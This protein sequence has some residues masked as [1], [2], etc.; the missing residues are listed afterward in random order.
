MNRLLFTLGDGI[1]AWLHKI[2]FRPSNSDLV[3]NPDGSLKFEGSDWL[4]MF[5]LWVSIISFVLLMVPMVWWSWRY[6]RQPGVPAIRT[7]NHNTAL[8]VTWVV[9]P[10]IVM[11]FIFFWG[12]HGYM[13]TLIAPGNAIEVMITARKWSWAATYPN[14]ATSPESVYLDYRDEGDKQ[15]RGNERVPI[16]VVP[17]G[18]PIK[19]RM[20][21]EDVIHSFYV[22]DMRVKMDVFP[23]RYTSLSFTPVFSTPNPEGSQVG[24]LMEDKDK[25]FS[26]KFLHRDHYLFCAEYCGE[27][28]SE[29]AGIIRVVSKEDYATIVAKWG[30]ID[31][32]TAPAALGE[33]VWKNNCSACHSLDGTAGTGPS[34]KGDLFSSTK[35]HEFESGPPLD[36][37]Q[38]NAWENYI[39]ESIEYPQ[40]KIV[41]GYANGNMPSYKGLSESR[42]NG[43]IAYMR[44]LNGKGRPEDEIV[45]KAEAAA[46]PGMAP[47]PPAPPSPA[48]K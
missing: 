46:A 12:F 9:V 21:S 40:A 4:F 33:I 22:P 34:W 45:P 5:I 32:T 11:T 1:N 7:P 44:K 15:F 8:E 36:V 18:I 38:P 3:V 16:F 41:K 43:V 26:A 42:I 27:N 14:G 24:V 13:K 10:L 35:P 39:R 28:H 31:K 17:A 48:P 19:F 47:A 25:H 6:R 30:D 20:S 29:M 2:W 37:S 23:N